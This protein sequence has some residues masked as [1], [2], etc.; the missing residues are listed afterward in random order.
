MVI[1]AD[2]TMSS[3]GDVCAVCE[4][5]VLYVHPSDDLKTRNLDE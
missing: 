5:R 2:R 1:H 4:T 3:V